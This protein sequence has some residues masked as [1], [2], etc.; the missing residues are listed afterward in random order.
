V[1]GPFAA[2]WQA[3]Q[4]RLGCAINEAHTSWLAEEHFEYG[5]MFWRKDND[6]VL[7]VHDSGAW[8]AYQNTWFEG[9]P[10]YSCPESTPEESPPTPWRGFGKVWC[11]HTE[12]R[13]GLGWATDAEHG[14]DGTVQDFEHGAIL[15]TNTGATYVLFGDGAWTQR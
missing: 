9:D 13:N 5:R 4:D 11:T 10:T 8:G 14:F 2:I 15:R 7:A 12:V 6:G 1:T 3:E